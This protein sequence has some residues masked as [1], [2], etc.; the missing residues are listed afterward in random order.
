[1]RKRKAIV[2]EKT[3]GFFLVLDSD[4]AF[5][6]MRSRFKAEV[7]DE[8][9]LAAIQLN[10]TIKTVLSIA[11]VF[12]LT[13]LASLGWS[14]WK[15][16]VVVA[17]LSVDI[18]PSLEFSLDK[19]T[20]IISVKAKNDDA[21]Q[22][23]QG[24]NLKGRILT[25]AMKLLVDRAVELNF[26]NQEN[27]WIVL[28]LSQ[29]SEQSA[30]TGEPDVPA[31]SEG[32]KLS[33]TG[34]AEVDCQA[35]LSELN[36]T[37][38]AENLDLRVVMFKLT[39]QDNVEAKKNGLSTGEYALWQT[40]ETAGISVPQQAVKNSAER[41]QLLEA[42]AVQSELKHNPKVIKPKLPAGSSKQV[43]K[44]TQDPK[45][46]DKITE[47][48]N[49]L[50]VKSKS[51]IKFNSV[52]KYN[53]EVKLNSVVKSKPKVKLPEIKLNFEVKSKP[54]IKLPEIKLNSVVKSKPEVK[55]NSDSINGKTTNFISFEDKNN[56]KIKVESKESKE[57]KESKESKDNKESKSKESKT[58]SEKKQSKF[59]LNNNYK[60]PFY[61]NNQLTP[62]LFNRK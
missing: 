41:S 26:L 50:E 21:L 58:T 37:I 46:G 33:Q 56:S 47:K 16:P 29:G 8:I 27:K 20:H 24:V 62:S 15:T 55:S 53:P 57:N 23:L 42:P 11:A 18:N 9:E 40:A 6:R 10:T 36:E 49:L 17:T 13:F 7:G 59:Y 5:R 35:L 4:G 31:V 60:F 32:K 45:K 39:S 25:G 34:F 28:G 12:L 19:G 48:Q 43:S 38:A 30:G 54:E 22:L 52:V 51:E 61:S 3:G 14:S 1:M 2:L 44:K